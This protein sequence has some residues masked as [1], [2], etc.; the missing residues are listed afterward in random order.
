MSNFVSNVQLLFQALTG[1]AFSKLHPIPCVVIFNCISDYPVNAFDGSKYILLLENSWLGGKNSFLGVAYI[2]VGFL[3]IVSA[4]V[5]IIIHLKFS[6]W[7]VHMCVIT[8]TIKLYVHSI[9]RV[10]Y[11]IYFI[12]I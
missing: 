11:Y 5:L 12:Y 9:C 7:L 8:T 2:V 1:Y 4:V 3:S 10:N 6:R